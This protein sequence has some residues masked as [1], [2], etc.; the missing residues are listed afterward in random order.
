MFLITE[1]KHPKEA[2]W[3]SRGALWF[4]V[5]EGGVCLGKEGHAVWQE[6]LVVHFWQVRE[7]RVCAGAEVTLTL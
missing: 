7:Q 3:V 6:K 4:L 5:S 2:T 1:T